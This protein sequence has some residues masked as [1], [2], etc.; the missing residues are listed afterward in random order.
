M[1]PYHGAY[2]RQQDLAP[3]TFNTYGLSPDVKQ[4]HFS[5]VPGLSKNDAIEM[6]TSMSRIA[7]QLTDMAANGMCTDD[8]D[9]PTLAYATLFYTTCVAA[10]LEA[11]E[12]TT[13]S[14][15]QV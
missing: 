12:V 8:L 13:D 10:L 9:R 5:A 6:A 1:R 2:L 15:R 14:A 7:Q 11:V 3:V 4:P